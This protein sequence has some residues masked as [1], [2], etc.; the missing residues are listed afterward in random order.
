MALTEW[1]K[2]KTAI[3]QFCSSSVMYVI[4]ND[5]DSTF[6]VHFSKLFSLESG[7]GILR[8]LISVLI[9]GTGEWQGKWTLKYNV[10]NNFNQDCVSV[11]RSTLLLCYLIWR[12]LIWPL[13]HCWVRNS[14]HPAVRWNL[15]CILVYLGCF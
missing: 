12:L 15:K 6:I 7:F 8:F 13:S 11:D 2:K 3:L 5:W 9:S 1:L 4:Y 14:F 10:L